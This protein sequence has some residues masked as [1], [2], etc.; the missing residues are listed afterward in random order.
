MSVTKQFYEDDHCADDTV[1]WRLN[2]HMQKFHYDEMQLLEKK[3][4]QPN[5]DHAQI[6]LQINKHAQS[7]LDLTLEQEDL[8]ERMELAA[9][10]ITH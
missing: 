8:E 4:S 9:E 2:D 10:V 6:E 1:A 5:V 7:I 3:L